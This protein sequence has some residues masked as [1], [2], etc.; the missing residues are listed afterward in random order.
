MLFIYSDNL[1][2]KWVNGKWETPVVFQFKGNDITE[3]DAAYEKAKGKHPSK[4]KGVGCQCLAE[5]D[6]MTSAL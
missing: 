4:E 2:A 5:S 3:A 6:S 1:K